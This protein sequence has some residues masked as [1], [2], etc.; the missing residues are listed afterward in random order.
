MKNYKTL[1]KLESQLLHSFYKQGTNHARIFCKH[2]STSSDIP[3]NMFELYA[4][5]SHWMGVYERNPIKT[6]PITNQIL[7]ER[8]QIEKERNSRLDLESMIDQKSAVW[9]SESKRVGAIGV[10]L[11]CTTMWTKEG[12]RHAVTL[13]QVS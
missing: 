5:N 7:D 6:G 11:G 8:K 3:R 13:I 4:K 2:K 10:K 12:L 1:C 9:T